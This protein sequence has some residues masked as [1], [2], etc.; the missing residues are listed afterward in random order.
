MYVQ[1]VIT[2]N[3]TPVQAEPTERLLQPLSSLALTIT[4]LIKL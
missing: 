4:E 3:T 1:C 2:A